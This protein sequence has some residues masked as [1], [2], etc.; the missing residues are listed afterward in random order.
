MSNTQFFQVELDDYA[1]P[2]FYSGSKHYF[3]TMEQIHE[4]ISAI[5]SDDFFAPKFK[6]L[7]ATYHTYRSGDTEVT[8]P[9]AYREVLFLKPAVLL[10][11]EEGHLNYYEWEHTN[12]WGFPYYMKCDYAD[13]THLWLK[14]D[15][16]Y[17]RHVIARFKNLQYQNSVEEWCPLKMYWGFPKIIVEDGGI[18]RNL[19]A[20]RE[21][22]FETRVE[23][24][25]DW[26]NFQKQKD[27]DFCEFCNDIF[28]DG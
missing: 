18:T 27:V 10:H 4:W 26:K 23:A 12:I 21:K 20:V 22:I 14:C 3:G 17:Y 11:K 1:A 9:V 15:Q 8:H 24:E 28:G 13:V 19:L 6:R 25:D 7:C 5:E 16:K 2:G